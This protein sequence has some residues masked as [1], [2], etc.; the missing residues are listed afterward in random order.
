MGIFSS[1]AESSSRQAVDVKKSG[2]LQIEHGEPQHL[3]S[4]WEKPPDTEG[5]AD[6]GRRKLGG[7]E[8]PISKEEHSWWAALLQ[9]D[10]VG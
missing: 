8:P 5:G 7:W 4:R 9:K 6:T 1:L 2:G 3:G 10:G